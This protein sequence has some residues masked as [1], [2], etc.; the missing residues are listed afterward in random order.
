M[1]SLYYKNF[2]E[3]IVNKF[4]IVEMKKIVIYYINNILLIEDFYIH[5]HIQ[6]N[7]IDND[8][9]IYKVIN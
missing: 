9:I 1:I 5:Q 7:I 8:K 4:E 3:K 2:S 6:E